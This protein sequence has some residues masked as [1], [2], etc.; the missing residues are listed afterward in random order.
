LSTDSSLKAA[1]PNAA[2]TL[3]QLQAEWADLAARLAR[4][5]AEVQRREA[6]LA[7]HREQQAKL[8]AMLPLARQREADIQALSGQGFVAGHS[9]QD[10]MRERIEVERDL[11]TQT[12]RVAEAQA[13]LVESRQSRQ[14]MQADARRQLSERQAKARLQQAHLRQEGRK[15]DL[16]QDLTRLVAPVAGTVQQLVVHTPGGVVT[17]AQPLMVI[18]PQGADV[19]AEVVL[20]NKD[21]GFVRVGQEVAVKV[22]A[23]PFAQYGTVRARVSRV[24]ADAVVDDKTGL[25]VYPATVTLSNNS[26]DVDGRRVALAAGMSI[27]SEIRI[28]KRS[29]IDF[30]SSPLRVR[31]AESLGER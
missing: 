29:V 12:A 22:D 10:R 8:Q 21:I 26:V 7:T 15:S 16:R 20:E 19:T 5:D 31:V 6:E 4:L 25:A 17:A 9:G 14:A 3:A 24:A 2:D 23:F 27:K 1:G 13:A 30:L 11:A 18:V 28:G